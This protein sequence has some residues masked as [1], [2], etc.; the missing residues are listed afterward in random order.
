MRSTAGDDRGAIETAEQVL[1]LL[2][3][4]S[5]NST[6]KYAVLLGLMD[7]CLERATRDGS[8][9]DSVTTWQLAERV[10]ELYWPQT[11]PFLPAR[12]AVRTATETVLSQNKGGPAEILQHILDFR[13][14][15]APERSTPLGRARAA[16]PSAFDALIRHVE[17]KLM[18]MP[19]PLLPK[20][21]RGESRASLYTIQWGEDVTRRSIRRG[22]DNQIR[23]VGRTGEHLVRLAGLLRP[24]IQREWAAMVAD[25]NRELTGERQLEEFLFGSQRAA[26]AAVRHPLRELQEDRCFYCGNK[27]GSRVE[28]DHFVPWAR[29]PLDD[30]QNLVAVDPRC[31]NDKRDFLAA[32]S[33]VG[34]WSARNLQRTTDL[35]ELA[36]RA[37]WPSDDSRSGA[38]ARAIYLHLPATSQLWLGHRGRFEPVDPCALRNA[39]GAGTSECGIVGDGRDA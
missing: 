36:R 8:A 25:L 20:L 23:F 12:R 3:R 5:F 34:R 29:Y 16:A 26:L 1:L 39:L 27:L 37:G 31:N 11:L 13:A 24:L 33:H 30:V 7:V 15:H 2:D 6:Y 19:L 22:I 18:K 21:G 38:V 35:E 14:Q 28:V 17:W 4:G 9:P 32:T 10:I